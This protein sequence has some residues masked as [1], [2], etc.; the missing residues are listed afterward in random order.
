MRKIIAACS[1]F[2]LIECLV[3]TFVT[4]RANGVMVLATVFLVIW[5]I[6]IGA[7]RK[8][9]WFPATEPAAEP[10]AVE[11]QIY[12]DPHIRDRRDFIASVE[13][14]IVALTRKD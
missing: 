7:H 6:A 14:D 11:P 9:W 12:I 10:A 2:L 8:S 4:V 1:L 5:I 13:A 3:A